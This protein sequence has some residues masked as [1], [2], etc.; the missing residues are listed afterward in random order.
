M[1]SVCDCPWKKI[2]SWAP[3]WHRSPL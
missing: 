3:K 2:R 1:S